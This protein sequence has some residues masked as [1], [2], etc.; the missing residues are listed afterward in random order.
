MLDLG[1]IGS[2]RFRRLLLAKPNGQIASK[3][4]PNDHPSFSDI[5]KWGQAIRKFL[6]PRYEALPIFVRRG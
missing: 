1:E 6:L 4:L 3:H 2:N 5:P